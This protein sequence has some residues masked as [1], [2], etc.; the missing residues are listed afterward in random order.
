M[1][2]C[3]V[4]FFRNLVPTWLQPGRQNLPNR[5]LHLNSDYF[6]AWFLIGLGTLFCQFCLEVR[7]PRDPKTLKN[8]MFLQFFIFRPSCQQ[9]AIWS[10]FWSTLP[11]TWDP[12]STKSRPKSLPKSIHNRSKTMSKIWSVFWSILDRFWTRLGSQDGAMLRPCWPQNVQTSDFKNKANK[13]AS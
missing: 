13:N 12:K 3:G 11:S 2:G 1:I 5:K 8:Y 6:F 9:E 4:V 10:I 7:R